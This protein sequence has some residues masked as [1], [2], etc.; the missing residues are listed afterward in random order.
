MLLH[1]LP[2]SSQA[3]WEGASGPTLWR[4]SATGSTANGMLNGQRNECRKHRAASTR[5]RR[6]AWSSAATCARTAGTSSL[7]RPPTSWCGNPLLR[8]VDTAVLLPGLL[9]FD[10][11][12]ACDEGETEVSLNTAAE[13]DT[14]VLV[15]ELTE[16]SA[17]A[18][19]S[20]GSTSHTNT[21]PRH[22]PANAARTLADAYRCVAADVRVQRA[23]PG[24]QP[25]H[26]R[27]PGERAADR[28]GP[29]LQGRRAGHRLLTHH[30]H[31]RRRPLL[32]PGVNHLNYFLLSAVSSPCSL[33]AR[34]VIGFSPITSHVRRRPL[35][36]PGS[37]LHI[38]PALGVLA[39]AYLFPPPRCTC[40]GCHSEEE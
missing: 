31:V 15:E 19:R 34:A 20:A 5:W 27:E 11:P 26:Q 36:Q 37:N 39:F 6:R 7:S 29:A 16:T 38:D 28:E 33:S 25:H 10:A 12:A 18:A 1:V 30:L 9:P 23:Q 32:Q 24:Q 22:E 8:H 2:L 14:S 4:W 3:V 40:A 13:A 17:S 35:L 21:H